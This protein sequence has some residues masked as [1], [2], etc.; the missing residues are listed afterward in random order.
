MRDFRKSISYLIGAALFYLSN[1]LSNDYNGSF[2][3]YIDVEKD[4]M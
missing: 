3:L 4:N 2:F 1:D